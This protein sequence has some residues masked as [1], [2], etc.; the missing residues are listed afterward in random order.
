[1]L[2]LRRQTADLAKNLGDFR[3]VEAVS[4]NLDALAQELSGL[5]KGNRGEDADVRLDTGIDPGTITATQPSRRVR[6]GARP[7]GR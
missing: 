1:L 2:K 7:D 6:T 3:A 4:G 5:V